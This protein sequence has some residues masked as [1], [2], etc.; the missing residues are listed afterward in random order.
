[1]AMID[2]VNGKIR[3][4]CIIMNRG[5]IPNFGGVM[6]PI[7]QPR[8]I[9][10]HEVL[11]LLKMGVDLRGVDRNNNKNIV[12][13]NEQVVIKLVDEFENGKKPAQQPKQQSVQPKPVVVEKKVE[14]Q[15]KEVVVE[16]K[17]EEQ[18][19][20]VVVEKKVEEQHKE[21]VVEKKVE[22]QHKEVVVE[23]KVEEQK[24][25]NNVVKQQNQNKNKNNKKK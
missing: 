25:E 23:K 18:P 8:P 7:L 1:M 22:E 16:K 3:V 14:E 2:K 6:G 15:H 5:V 21:V 20:E 9:E 24:V 4:N 12:N 13:L 10:L 11:L 19:K 17:V